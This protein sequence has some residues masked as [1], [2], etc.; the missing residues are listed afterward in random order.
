MLTLSY[1]GDWLAVA[2]DGETVKRHFWALVQALR[3][4]L[5]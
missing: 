3:A 5:G 2:P 4:R 1:P